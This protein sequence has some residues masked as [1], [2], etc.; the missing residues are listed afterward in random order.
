VAFGFSLS[1]G[2]KLRVLSQSPFY[3]KAVATP[4]TFET[5]EKNEKDFFHPIFHTR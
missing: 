2:Q 1:S 4:E 3:I 5:L